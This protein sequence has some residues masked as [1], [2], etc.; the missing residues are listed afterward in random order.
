MGRDGTGVGENDA[1]C[2]G[3]VVG[4]GGGGEGRREGSERVSGWVEWMADSEMDGID[5]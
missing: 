5:N 2:C 1:W 3:W 4:C